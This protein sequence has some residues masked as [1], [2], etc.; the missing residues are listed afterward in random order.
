[1]Q[2]K[3]L[4]L[5][6]FGPYINETVD[7]ERFQEAGLFLI[8]GKTGAG[9]TT[10]FDGMTYALFGETSGQVRSGKEMRSMFATPE[11]ETRVTFSF[12]H[13]G[14]VYEISRAPEQELKKLRG[15]GTRKKMMQVSL[16]IFDSQLQEEK[17]FTKKA[18]VD[19]LIS[20]LLHI[21]A[22]QFFQIVL[23]PQGEFRNFLIASSNEKEKLLRHLFGTEMYQRL[24]E[25]LRNKQ[26]ELADLLSQQQHQIEALVQQ[27]QWQSEAKPFVT[28]TE[29]LTDW[30]TELTTLEEQQATSAKQLEQ[31][32]VQAKQALD[33]LYVGKEQAKQLAEYQKLQV[34][35]TLLEEQAAERAVQETQLQRLKWIQA[36]TEV[37]NN[38]EQLQEDIVQA[39]T[40]LTQKQAQLQATEQEL[41]QW[42]AQTADIAVVRQK[43]Q[44]LSKARQQL[45]TQLPQALEIQTL[46]QEQQTVQQTGERLQASLDA[47]QQQLQAIGEQE[48]TYEAQLVQQASLQQTEL[49][50]VQAEN[51]VA[52]FQES[53]NSLQTLQNQR[54]TIETDLTKKRQHLAEQVAQLT[55]LEAQ[56]TD[57]E[58][59]Y[60]K[61]QIA[62]LQLLLKP[63][64]P[65]LVCGATEH[66]KTEH[67]VYTT[68]EVMQSEVD[69]AHAEQAL[70]DA[71]QQHQQLLADIRYLEQQ[72]LAVD[73]QIERTMESVVDWRKQCIEL[74]VI[75]ETADILEQFKQQRSALEQAKAQMKHAEQ[76][77]VAVKENRQ[78]IEAQQA[79]IVTKQQTQQAQYQ[80]ITTKVT[81]L[82]EQ[83]QGQSYQGLQA[84]IAEIQNQETTCAK[85][86]QTYDEQGKLL[87]LQQTRL[88]SEVSTWQQQVKTL[89][90]KQTKL[91]ANLQAAIT[92]SAY[93]LTEDQLRAALPE[94]SQIAHLEQQL[95][96]YQQEQRLVNE[97]LQELATVATMTEP[98]LEQLTQAS[99]QQ[100]QQVDSQQ[101]QWMQAKETLRHNQRLYQTLEQ[102]AVDNQEQLDE[103][104]QLQQLFQ[105]MNG[106]N[107][108]KMSIERYVLQSFLVEILDVANQRL[109]QLT[110]GRYQFLLAEESGSYRS[111]TGLEINIY[112]DNAGMTRRAQTLSGGESFI[113]AL[114]L[115]LSLADVIQNRAGG[116][117]IEALFIDE[118]FGSL[119]EESLEMAMQALEMIESEGRLIGIISHVRELKDRVQQQLIVQANGNGQSRLKHHTV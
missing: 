57:C 80:A 18:E 32:K 39:Q 42:Q 64:E 83:L 102:L 1:M 14:R 108:L 56:V 28:L 85:T 77:L 61:M 103:L 109:L 22:K 98:D 68:E 117:S 45:E 63:G 52:H 79:Q 91:Q 58:H 44:D 90:E 86:V 100:Q 104:G 19:Q 99:E 33:A 59:N 54:A 34:R 88:E 17:Q 75:D 16:T 15:E 96:T 35:Q 66:V 40:Q 89:S 82:K 67:Q 21:N 114:A 69:L 43:Q 74:L 3:K 97:R 13:Q 27:F 47:V 6:N 53:Q 107:P 29:T 78:A 2:P 25:W 48:I 93:A 9:K 106:D 72:H 5:Q 73:E 111:S 23:L 119:D 7:F 41:D 101:Q 112:D 81:L 26:K 116:I 49:V 8:S 95:A 55:V 37:L 110:R 65:C 105:T 70:K 92:A 71:N 38:L 31:A 30:Q 94:T 20:D 113:A 24:N 84:K 76:A 62:R 12:E 115:A 10:L 60:A 36:Q 87:A 51:V 4:I 46:E 118:G 11:E 50:L